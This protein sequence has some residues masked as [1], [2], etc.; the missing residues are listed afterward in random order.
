MEL[1][2]EPTVARSFFDSHR[3]KDYTSSDIRTWREKII[4]NKDHGFRPQS[5]LCKEIVKYQNVMRNT[6]R[7]RT[8]AL[9][10]NFGVLLLDNSARLLSVI[11]CRKNLEVIAEQMDSSLLISSDRRDDK[12]IFIGDEQE[13]FRGQVL[14]WPSCS[15]L[16]AEDC[17]WS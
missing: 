2:P 13:R 5:K 4:K 8:P 12:K 7:C 10:Q 15:W 11:F 16:G 6:D 3:E 9:A 14:R 17:K 1:D